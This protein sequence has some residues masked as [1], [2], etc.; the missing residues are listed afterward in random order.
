MKV[1]DALTLSSNTLKT[2]DADLTAK[3]TLNTNSLIDSTGGTLKISGTVD[4]SSE[5]AI[6]GTVLD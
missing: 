1:L 4:S 3:V 2:G 5:I 6:P